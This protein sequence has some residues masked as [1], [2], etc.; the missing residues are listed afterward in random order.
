MIRYTI[1]HYCPSCVCV[2]IYSDPTL[3]NYVTGI[4]ARAS[5]QKLFSRSA[6]FQA[7]DLQN[8]IISLMSKFEL[9]LLWSADNL[10]IPSLLPSEND[11]YGSNA[12]VRV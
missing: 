6:I 7:D 1:C 9:A 12:P 3:I 4:M 2:Y 8:Y 11:R 5:L 10:L